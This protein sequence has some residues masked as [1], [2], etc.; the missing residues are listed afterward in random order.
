MF[1]NIQEYIRKKGIRLVILDVDGTMKDLVLEHM[2]AIKE[3]ARIRQTSENS[4]DIRVIIAINNFFMCFVKCGLFP[5]NS[6]M[7]NILCFV[8]CILFCEPFKN[9][10]CEYLTEYY[11]RRKI[12]DNTSELLDEIVKSGAKYVIISKN[13]QSINF[14]S[15]N[16]TFTQNNIYISDG[17]KLG[18]FKNLIESTAVSESKDILPEEVLII[19]DNFWD[20]VIPAMRLK[21]NVLWCNKYFSS[22]KRRCIHYLSKIFYKKALGNKEANSIW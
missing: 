11:K 19:G 20:D 3:I 7:Q 17:D 12:F 18:L 6:V 4:K 22:S 2:C 1:N 15:G 13:S 16:W 5:T 10:R 8:N 9:F 21:A 14:F